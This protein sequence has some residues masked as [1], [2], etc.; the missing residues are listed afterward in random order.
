MV[1][2]DIALAAR[3]ADRLIWMK[4]GV[5][6]ADGPVAETLSAKMMAQVFDV[7]ATIDQSGG[8]PV[9]TIEDMID[10]IPLV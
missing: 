2:H 4:Q 8:F 6:V 9:M 1:M 10:T 5:I 3:F 7:K